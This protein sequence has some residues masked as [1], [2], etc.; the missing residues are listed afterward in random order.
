MDNPNFANELKSNKIGGYPWNL[1]LWNLSRWLRK[2][3]SGKAADEYYDKAIKITKENP[4]NVTMY[5][6]SNC[7]IAD[8]LLYKTHKGQIKQSE[9]EKEMLR[10]LTNFNKLSTVDTMVN[11][12][13]F[14]DITSSSL[15][16]KLK[17]LA[18]SYLR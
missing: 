18:N 17:I 10:A 9:A 16:N 11:H 8:L 12:F 7:M 13:A 5:A 6:F 4:D 1:V 2:N 3:N 15:P 14:D